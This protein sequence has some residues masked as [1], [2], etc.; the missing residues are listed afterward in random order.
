MSAAARAAMTGSA[1]PRSSAVTS[2]APGVEQRGH[3]VAVASAEHVS[4]G[5]A[6]GFMQVNHGKP[7][8][9]RRLRGGDRIV[10]YS[11]TAEFRGPGK[12]QAFTAIGAVL[13]AAPYQADMGGG[14]CPFRRDVDWWQF[15]QPAPILPLLERLEFALR[16]GKNWGYSFRFGLF[17]ISAHDMALIAAAMGARV[18]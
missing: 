17:A 14:F 13:D 1:S 6:Q 18:V 7:A 3:W 5:R 8:P 11:P 15:E 4:L 12:L 2:A 10:Y 9:L 16:G